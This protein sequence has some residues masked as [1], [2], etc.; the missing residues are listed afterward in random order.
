MAF[1]K[2]IKNEPYTFKYIFLQPDKLY[3]ILFTIKKVEAHESRSN[4]E[5]INKHKKKYRK[6]NN[7]HPFVLI[8]AI[9]P[10]IEYYEAQIQTLF[11]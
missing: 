6:L 2:K 9:D 5:V 8:S 11:T 10:Q 3:F 1:S 7:I 4:S